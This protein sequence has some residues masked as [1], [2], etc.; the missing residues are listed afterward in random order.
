MSA[1]LDRRT[2]L[3]LGAGVLGVATTPAWLRPRERLVRLTVPVMGTVAELAVPARHEAFARQALGAA[4]DELR[5]I[6]GL[7]TRFTADS[8]VGRFNAASTDA[9]V[10]VAPETSRNQGTPPGAV[11]AGGKASTASST[12]AR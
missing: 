10:P 12:Q 3:A 11:S 8:D 5:R 2:F 6:E 9:R 1:T 4:A 7:M